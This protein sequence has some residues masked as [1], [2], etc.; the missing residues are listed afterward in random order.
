MAKHHVALVTQEAA[1]LPCLV[2]VIYG[3]TAE[4]RSWLIGSTDS[5]S[6]SLLCEE[7]IE[8]VN[9]HSVFL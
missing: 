1:N 3:E 6:S 9:S 7:C 5:T 2:V 8:L 4:T